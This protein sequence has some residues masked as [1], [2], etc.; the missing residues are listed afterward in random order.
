MVPTIPD[1]VAGG[2]PMSGLVSSSTF[3]V[4]RQ[5]LV[6]AVDPERLEITYEFMEP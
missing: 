2:E 5:H 4:H 6:P 3:W 1:T